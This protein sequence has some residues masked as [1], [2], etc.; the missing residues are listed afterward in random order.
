MKG[1]KTKQ[2]FIGA[3]IFIPN[4]LAERCHILVKTIESFYSNYIHY[5]R[6]ADTFFKALS[7]RIYQENEI[8]ANKINSWSNFLTKLEK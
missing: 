7:R 8:M 2:E 1:K 4:I 3:V 5:N 6:D